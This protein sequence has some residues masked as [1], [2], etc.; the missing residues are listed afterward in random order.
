[1]KITWNWLADY[2]DL[3]GLT[4]QQVA[5]D[6]T[7]AGIPVEWMEPFAYPVERVVVGEVLSADPHPNANRLRV[8]R[9]T[10][11][12]EA[13]VTIVCGA[14]NV[15][16]G[17]R[18]PVA[19]EGARLPD[20]TIGRSTLR[21]V[22]SQGMICSAQELGLPV[23]S[24]AK[25]QTD[26]IFVLPGDAP[27]GLSIA[28]YLGLGDMVMELEL[29][30]NR[31]D[32]LSL[33]GV[34]YEVGAIYGRTVRM[35]SADTG[36]VQ[37]ASGMA[38]S[39]GND[40]VAAKET[41]PGEPGEHG[42]H[43]EHDAGAGPA[44]ELPLTATVDTPLC[45]LYSVQAVT[46][47]ALGPAPIWMQ[48]RL[49]AVGMRPIS[50][51]VDITNYVMLEW[52]QPLHAFDYDV[53]AHHHIVVRQAEVA[54]GLETLDG[55]VRQLSPSMIVIA[56]PEK[57]LGLGGVM[58][59]RNSEVTHTTRS[60]V[61]ES[62]LF[63]PIVTRRTGKALQLRSEAGLRFEK[64]TDPD[65]VG[66]ALA[67]AVALIQL[68]AGGRVASP[69]VVKR[70]PLAT[71][72][73][74]ALSGMSSAASATGSLDAD[75]HQRPA[76][77]CLDAPRVSAF[78]GCDYAIDELV[79]VCRRLQFPVQREGQRLSVEIPARRPDITREEDM[80]EEFARLLSYDR[81]PATE[82][83]G[84][85]TP[86]RL[87]PEQALR[88]RLR[89]HLV[90]VGLTEVWTYSLVPGFVVTRTGLPADHALAQMGELQNP[91]SED[92]R[93]LRSSMLF[94]LL[95]V[96]QY[97]SHRRIRDI[98]VFEIGTVF[99]PRALP[100]TEQPTERQ[101]LALFLAGQAMAESP[102]GKPRALDFFDAKGIV[103]HL[104][105]LLGLRARAVFLPADEPYLHA[106][107]SARILIDGREVG[108]VG[109]LRQSVARE[110]GIGA[111]F[112]AELC[113][114]SLAASAEVGLTVAELPK[115]PGVARDL[116][117]VA[118]RSLAAADLVANV[119]AAGGTELQAVTIFDVYT[120]DHV[121]SDAKSLALRLTFQAQDRTLTDDEVSDYVNRIL[122]SAARLGAAIRH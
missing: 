68:Y 76:V 50:N 48:M 67:R 41:A 37:P 8:C 89:T 18:V 5:M 44:S 81:I 104:L 101:V 9:V 24:L 71:T 51:L 110:Y 79:D 56:D 10:V 84:P 74:G 36:W 21:G 77:I 42:E 90:S 4:P 113:L 85:L 45:P 122:A 100:M 117:F 2:V 1:M 46:G 16:A 75:L 26:G 53:I 27:L 118:P 105:A 115:F 34:A 38:R 87:T 39:D 33:R 69:A 93:F 59:G 19:L 86:G 108:V 94:A 58:G 64:G 106:G 49:L 96:A 78:L 62:A 11:G 32:C 97:N 63:D 31:S 20:L 23:R 3:D 116:A 103:E 52:G 73:D 47:V 114:A 28:D 14:A 30:P 95:D 99:S 61:I 121:G 120:G 66:P 83:H 35:P 7:H 102:H 88:R 13:P 55:Q 43:G 40:A 25:E 57:A 6:L 29:T 72:S 92:R 111:G 107:Q 65:A 54:E 109:Q 22:E 98:R 80:I 70:P 17:Q 60:V 12:T 112:Y 119:R 82:M 91:L 15:A